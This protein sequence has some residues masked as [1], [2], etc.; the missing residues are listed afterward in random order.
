[1]DVTAYATNPPPSSHTRPSQAPI[2]RDPPRSGPRLGLGLGLGR[3]ETLTRRAA[4]TPGLISFAGGLPAPGEFP[5]SKLA[6]SFVRALQTPSCPALQYGW[7]EGD[8]D[9]RS[10]IAGQLRRRGASVTRDDVI[11]TSGAQ[12][13]VSLAAQMVRGPDARIGVD[14]ESYP[15]ALELFRALGATVIDDGSHVDAYYLMPAVSNPRGRRLSPHGR[16]KVLSTLRPIIEDDAYADLCFDG[17]VP[18]PLLAE[19]PDRVFH[20]GTFSKTLCPGL[21]VGWLVPPRALRADVLKL[22]QADDLQAASLPQAI[23]EDYLRN[24]DFDQRLVRLREFYARRAARMEQALRRYLPGWRFESPAG[25]F[26][27]WVE[28]DAEPNEAFFL[29]AAIEHGV[30]FD[31]GSLF[32]ANGAVTPFALRLCFSSVSRDEDLDEGVRRLARCWAEVA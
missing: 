19:A 17:A 29:A 2:S 15:G 20:V 1:M 26:A 4:D 22:K 16:A 23:L 5:R 28:P 25:G 3:F 27:I 13:A 24:E 14:A 21:R 11:V 6:A 31:P 18:R 30:A 8:E 32:R 10:W 12:Q 7:P 9:L